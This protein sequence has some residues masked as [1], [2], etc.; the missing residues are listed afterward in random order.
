MFV[1]CGMHYVRCNVHCAN[2]PHSAAQETN[3]IPRSC[4]EQ[5][6]EVKKKSEGVKHYFLDVIMK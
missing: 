4:A 6:T 5:L 1:R 3:N 2:D